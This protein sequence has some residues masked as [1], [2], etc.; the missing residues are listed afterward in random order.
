MKA[1]V[2][3]TPVGILCGRDCIYLD[4][5]EQNELRQL[6]IQG[7]LNSRLIGINRDKPLKNIEF[8]PYL[9][10][11]ERVIAMTSCELDTHENAVKRDDEAEWASFMEIQDSPWL[12]QLPIRNDIDRS[13]YRHFRVYTYDVVFDVF[14]AS[15][16]WQI[17]FRQPE[18][19]PC[20]FQQSENAQKQ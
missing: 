11:F 13:I 17:D 9:L 20:G 2:L 3:D 4:S 10:T 14:A 12:N 5:A 16:T 1:V 8:I 15:F 6:M 18:N 19:P 7:E